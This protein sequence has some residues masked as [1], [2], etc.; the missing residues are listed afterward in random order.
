MTPW[1]SL[2]TPHCHWDEGVAVLVL[3][4]VQGRVLTVCKHSSLGNLW[5]VFQG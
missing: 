3:G 1:W 4:S 5:M 2:S